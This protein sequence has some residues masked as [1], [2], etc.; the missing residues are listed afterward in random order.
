MKNKENEYYSPIPMVML[1]TMITGIVFEAVFF[2][3]FKAFEQ[4]WMRFCALMSGV[5]AYHM[6]IR[7]L[8]PVILAAIF[9]KQY[10]NESWWFQERKWESELYRFLNVKNWK[11]KALT[12]D[13]SEFSL[14][15]HSLEEITNNMCHAEL[16][17][18]LIALLSFT[19]LFFAVFFEAAWILLIIAILGALFDLSFVVLQRYN[20]PRVVRLI[21]QKE[22]HRGLSVCTTIANKKKKT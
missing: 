19:S 4:N 2:I 18:E 21:T 12:Y 3:L 6:F 5:I 10:D 20:R 7:F 9:H 11:V 8:S 17:H 14:K 16:V 22:I 13:P 15:K 1:F